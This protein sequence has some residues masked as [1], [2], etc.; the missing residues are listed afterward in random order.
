MHRLLRNG[1]G[2]A[3]MEILGEKVYLQE[4][5]VYSSDLTQIGFRPDRPDRYRFVPD[6]L[7]RRSIEFFATV[8]I[9]GG[10]SVDR[11]SVIPTLEVVDIESGKTAI[12]YPVPPPCGATGEPCNDGNDVNH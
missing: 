5:D 11:A 2:G 10:D 1:A 9:T 12:V 4:K 6:F 8:T 3:L 7:N